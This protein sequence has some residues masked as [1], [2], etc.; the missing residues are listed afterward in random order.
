M[1]SRR[2]INGPVYTV[3]VD[4]AKRFLAE[5]PEYRIRWSFR[6]NNWQIE[7]VY[8]R[9]ALQA[10]DISPENDG[11]IR[12]R[13]G[14]WLVMEIQPGD[15]MACPSI[16]AHYPQLQRCGLTLKVPIRATAETVCTDCKKRG[17]DGRHMAAYWPLDETFLDHMRKTDPLRD[18]IRR[19]S[20]EA[21]S[22]N[23]AREADIDR[24]GSNE[25]QAASADLF[26]RIVGINQWGYT[27]SNK[28]IHRDKGIT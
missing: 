27:G 15:R 9:G 24:R 12:E 3:P 10:S 21:D 1:D 17:R 26:N 8:G 11:L 22:H 4:F 28:N 6:R 25:G 23:E 16:V 19:V 13:D 7:Q 14:Y 18:G 2:I 5:F 20:R